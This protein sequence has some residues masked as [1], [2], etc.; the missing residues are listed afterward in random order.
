M[1]LLVRFE[2]Y[3]IGKATELVVELNIAC[4]G[5]KKKAIMKYH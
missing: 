4:R 3:D 2:I 5:K 1:V